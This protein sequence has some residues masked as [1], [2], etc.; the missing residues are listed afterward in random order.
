MTQPT[1]KVAGAMNTDT[2]SA[3]IICSKAD[4]AISVISL[5]NVLCYYRRG[6]V[7][8]GRGARGGEGRGGGV[9]MYA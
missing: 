9:F 6:K 5:N 4:Y 2:K 7:R 1:T 8:E 3:V